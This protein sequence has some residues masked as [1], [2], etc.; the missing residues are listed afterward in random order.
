M[1]ILTD[2]LGATAYDGGN[3]VITILHHT[4]PSDF[5]RYFYASLGA[6]ANASFS[7][8]ARLVDSLLRS[9]IN[10]IIIIITFM[11]LLFYLGFSSKLSRGSYRDSTIL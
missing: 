2:N 10:N 6:V 11:I 8:N 7:F 4:F 3:T 9:I 5:V 1:L